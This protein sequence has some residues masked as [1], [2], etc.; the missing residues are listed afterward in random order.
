[1][2]HRYIILLAISAIFAT[3]VFPIVDAVADN[4]TCVLKAG[5]EDVRLYVQDK[6]DAGNDQDKIFEGWIKA[7]QSVKIK[8]QTG[9]ITY[10][11]KVRSGDR[12]HGDNHAR[13]R[14][15][16]TIRVP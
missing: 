4:K 7:G 9:R 13:C 3:S 15:G 6:D 10:S 2:K 8:S 1:M 12:T 16:N 5:T 11:Y 14:D